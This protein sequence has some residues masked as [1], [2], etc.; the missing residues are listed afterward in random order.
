MSAPDWVVVMA[1]AAFLALCVVG[2]SFDLSRRRARRSRA[3][4]VEARD[5]TP[6]QRE[7]EVRDL[8]QLFYGHDEWSPRRRTEG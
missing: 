5:T 2:F 8:N 4:L 3:T 1:L 6:A 7:A